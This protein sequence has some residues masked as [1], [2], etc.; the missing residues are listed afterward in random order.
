MSKLTAQQ[1]LFVQEYVK[2]GNATQAYKKAYPKSLKWL[3]KSVWS[4]S[5]DL[6]ANVK[7]SQRVD[8]L[9]KELAKENLW[10]KS[11]MIRTLKDIANVEY[12][13]NSERI[14]AIKQASSMLGYDTPQETNNENK[15]ARNSIIINT[16]ANRD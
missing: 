2:C 10:E 8:E 15:E 11:E 14:Q 5:S 4:K 1:E 16:N 6:L 3:D 12:Q 9:K 7:V 13:N